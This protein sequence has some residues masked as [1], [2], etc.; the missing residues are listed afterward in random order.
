MA[1]GESNDHVTHMPRMV[2]RVT[3]IRF[4]PNVSKTAGDRDSV[5]ITKIGNGLRGIE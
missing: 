5:P 3:P 4:E 1:Y 2:K